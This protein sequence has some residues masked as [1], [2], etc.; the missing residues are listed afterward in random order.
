[1]TKRMKIGVSCS[2]IYLSSWIVKFRFLIF[3]I[4]RYQTS[5]VISLSTAC[6]KLSPSSIHHQGTVIP[7]FSSMSANFSS[8]GCLK[9]QA[10]LSLIFRFLSFWGGWI[11]EMI[12]ILSITIVRSLKLLSH[13]NHHHQ[14]TQDQKLLHKLQEVLEFPKSEFRF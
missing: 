9:K 8:F 10:T 5:S 7:Y 14:S 11:S 2:D 6:S 1:M 4:W 3:L 13:H 12:V